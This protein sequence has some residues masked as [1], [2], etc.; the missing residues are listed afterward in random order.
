MKRRRI[1]NRASRA[2]LVSAV[3]AV[4]P[5][6]VRGT[7]NIT[8]QSGSSFS[9]THTPNMGTPTVYKLSTGF[10][11][12]S[13]SMPTPSS[14]QYGLRSIS[15][16]GNTPVVG[17]PQTAASGSVG[18]YTTGLNIGLTLSSGTGITQDDPSN[19][20]G[21]NYSE[22]KFNVDA[23]WNINANVGPILDSDI[24]F[25]LGGTIPTGDSAQIAVNLH[26][27]NTI[28]NAVL[29]DL[30]DTQTLTSATTLPLPYSNTILLGGGSLPSGARVHVTG[31]I[32]IRAKDPTNPT[33]LGGILD[34][35]QPLF[36]DMDAAT[37]QTWL[38]D[39]PVLASKGVATTTFD[40][41]TQQNWINQMSQPSAIPTGQNARA[42]F[43]G[44]V[45]TPKTMD[46]TNAE[47]LGMV[48]IDD[49]GL[50]MQALQPS[51]GLINF[52]TTYGNSVFWVRNLHEFD[53]VAN[54]AGHTI[55]V[56]LN[57]GN[58]FEVINDAPGPLNFG[59]IISGSGEIVK[60][61]MGPMVLSA[62]NAYT[63]GTEVDAGV[64]N[65]N[66]DGALG[67]GGV[68][69]AGGLLNINTPNPFNGQS[70]LVQVQSGGQLVVGT[71]DLVNGINY[72]LDVQN[73]AC[74]TSPPA[75]L[76][77]L[78]AAAGG[79]LNLHPG[80]MIGH[81]SFD[82]LS[83]INVPS[84]VGTADLVKYTYGLSTD[85][86]S[87]GA[88]VSIGNGS[89]GLWGGL[90]G[91]KFSRTFGSLSD[92]THLNISGA[93]NLDSLGGQFVI[94]VPIGSV[95][96]PVGPSITKRGPGLVA[97]ESSNNTFSGA[98]GVESGPIAIDGNWVGGSVAVGTGAFAASLGGTGTIN[99]SVIIS[100]NGELHPGVYGTVA[101]FVGTGGFAGGNVSG[102]NATIEGAGALHTNALTL[103]NGSKLWFNLD[104]D[105]LPSGSGN[106]FV[107]I[108][109]NLTLLGTS[110]LNLIEG[111]DFD[112]NGIYPL[113]HFS[114]SFLG[115][116]SISL[117]SNFAADTG[118]GVAIV[119]DNQLG[120]QDVI[121][122]PLGLLVPEP[123]SAMVFI[124]APLLLMR[125]RRTVI[126][127][128]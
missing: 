52:D 78:N 16:T 87:L 6:L 83:P 47:S 71:A 37:P 27:V 8:F 46:F 108:N 123:V 124:G 61:G 2:L 95:A 12:A 22:L 126:D 114:G 96:G 14:Y 13:G 62:N 39:E 32:A 28:T 4:S 91:D 38:F 30:I 80:A 17:G 98:M 75:V 51:E 101:T 18:A 122:E 97:I 119:A 65:A 53:P 89:P 84:G 60:E 79:N 55:N 82:N 99:S 7:A 40:F 11:P 111:P 125:R 100:T 29:G 85:V 64:V 105:P 88:D 103:M 59:S 67:T 9:V 86:N 42:R 70:Q 58:E 110:V 109:G 31:S 102:S 127:H 66:V 107:D 117:A 34:P 1:C 118:M 112:P 74:L 54:A 121:L 94:N 93:A 90:G 116:G 26:Y 120:G 48:D 92:T 56:P 76:Q 63:G 10:I 33:G 36:I 20:F 35:K 43:L 113:M 68:V 57:L 77:S 44:T 3:F 106:D 73:L 45:N 5:Q 24:S 69:L 49:P 50:N 19:A 23:T 21:S 72:N 104:I 128:A 15:N 115:G 81:T 41:D 25:T